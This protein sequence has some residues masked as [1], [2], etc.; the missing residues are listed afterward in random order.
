MRHVQGGLHATDRRTWHVH[1]G[2][3]RRKGHLHPLRSVRQRLPA[4]QHHRGLRISRRP[5]SREG[6]GQGGH[7]QHL[8]LRPRGAGRGI[9]HAQG[10]FRPGQDGRPA[11]CA[12]RGLRAGHQLRRRP[13]HH[14]GSQR[15]DPAHHHRGQAAAAVHQLLPRM[16]QV[17]R[18]LLPGDSTQHLQ[19]Q[20]PHRHAGSHHQ[21]LLCKEDGH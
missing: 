8:P 19:R 9:W 18:D 4:R 14:G 3:D 16:D 12:G 17:C 7:R 2:A 15:A 20:E 21:D 13:D 1:P 6:S 10:C 5:R 11:A